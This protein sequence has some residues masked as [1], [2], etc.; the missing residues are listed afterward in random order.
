V[1]VTEEGSFGKRLAQR[2]GMFGERMKSGET[3]NEK[4]SSSYEVR[5]QGHEAV[6]LIFPPTTLNPT[7]K[8]GAAW[9]ISSS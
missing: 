5:E 7:T 9:F 3:R 8:Y 1:E 6:I 4:G 2:R